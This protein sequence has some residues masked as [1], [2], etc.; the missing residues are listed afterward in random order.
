MA[1]LT[2]PIS[3]SMLAAVE[4]DTDSETLEVTFNNGRTYAYENVPQQEYE[5][6]VNAPSPGRYYL[7]AIKD[8]FHTR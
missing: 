7:N 3:S 4:Y 8:Q 1:K 6:L 2:Q 5:G